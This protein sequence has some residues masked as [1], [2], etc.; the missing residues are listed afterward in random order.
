MHINLFNP[1][2][3]LK[4]VVECDISPSN[5]SEADFFTKPADIGTKSNRLLFSCHPKQA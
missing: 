2:F 3:E 1:Y 5:V 4:H